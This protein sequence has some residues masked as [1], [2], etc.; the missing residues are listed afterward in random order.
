MIT[1]S[2]GEPAPGWETTPT[3][4]SEFVLLRPSRFKHTEP[5][6]SLVD[7]PRRWTQLAAAKSGIE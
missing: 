2:R 5:K 6:L 3:A 7:A 1:V 4:V